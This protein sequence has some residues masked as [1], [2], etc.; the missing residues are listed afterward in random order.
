MENKK[1]KILLV[2]DDVPTREMY[3]NVFKDAGFE[4]IEAEDGL[5]GLDKAIE[6]TPDVIF[7][8][9]VM[10][11]MDGFQMIE[12]LKK[13]VATASIPVLISSHM[14]KEEDRQRANILGARFFIVKG[15]SSP[16]EVL[17]DVN[18][19]FLGGNEYRVEI[20]E[21]SLDAP[22]LSHD[23]GINNLKCPECNNKLVI[24]LLVGKNKEEIKANLICSSCGWQAK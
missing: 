18:S 2:D 4:V 15:F 8:G 17:G 5:E 9:I 16:R 1:R 10:P 7:T 22:K 23:F 12:A 19:I 11:K 13:N 3:V 20:D 24:K 21:Y 6:E 14:G